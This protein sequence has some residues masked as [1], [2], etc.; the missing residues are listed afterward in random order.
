MKPN[1]HSAE[2][3]T[4]SK[5]NSRPIRSSLMQAAAAASKNDP[6]NSAAAEIGFV[7]KPNQVFSHAVAPCGKCSGKLWDC[8]S[9]S[10]AVIRQRNETALRMMRNIP[11]K[12]QIKFTGLQLRDGL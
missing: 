4:E 10:P 6:A 3:R 9:I 1:R 8:Q 12:L 2:I 11:I 5:V 7:N